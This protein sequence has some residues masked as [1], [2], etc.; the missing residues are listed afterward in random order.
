MLIRPNR[1]VRAARR[2]AV[3]TISPEEGMELVRQSD[4]AGA[5]NAGVTARRDVR[6]LIKAS[7]NSV[8]DA[9]QRLDAL[10]YSLDTDLSTP[11]AKVAVHRLTGNPV[12][13]HRGSANAKDWLVSDALIALGRADR[14]D[15]R[16]ASARALTT[17]MREKYNRPVTAVGHSLGGRLAAKSG[18]DRS[19]SVNPA[20]G[21]RDAFRPRG[22]KETVLR[23]AA[24]A[25]SLLDLTRRGGNSE[26]LQQR[27][28]SNWAEALIP[29]ASFLRAHQVP[30]DAGGDASDPLASVT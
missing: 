8:P 30:L 4:A 5:W 7:Y 12:V 18:A 1:L 17:R 28:H 25:V 26:T 15:P 16:H 24:D 9:Q 3:D 11:E 19:I 6:Q 23:T 2:N 20:V 10:G 14:L 29:G 13:M 27:G 22:A 21:P